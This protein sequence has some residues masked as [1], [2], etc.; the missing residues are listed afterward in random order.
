MERWFTLREP[1][2]ERFGW[3]VQI[4]DEAIR[5]SRIVENNATG[6]LEHLDPFTTDCMFPG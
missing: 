2:G 5:W 6:P 3:I 4:D 1:Q